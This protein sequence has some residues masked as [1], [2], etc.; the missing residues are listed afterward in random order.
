MMSRLRAIH[1]GPTAIAVRLVS[2][3]VATVAA[4]AIPA[5]LVATATGHASHHWA[6]VTVA[7][8]AALI[9]IAAVAVRP[10]DPI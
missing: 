1:A 4:I 10:F 8:A 2:F 7:S 6:M 5:A 3:L 9:V